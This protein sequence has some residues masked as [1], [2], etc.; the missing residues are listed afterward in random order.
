MFDLAVFGISRRGTAGELDP[1]QIIELLLEGEDTD[2]KVV[3]K[4]CNVVKQRFVLVIGVAG[5]HSGV[6]EA[7]TC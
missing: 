6:D 3:N 2:S 1:H 5:G 4:G 7:G